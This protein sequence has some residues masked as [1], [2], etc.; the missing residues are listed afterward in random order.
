MKTFGFFA[1]FLLLF[2]LGTTL[3]PANGQNEQVASNRKVMNKVMPVYPRIARSM[4]LTGTVKLEILVAANG[5]PKSIQVKGG[6]P[7]L[8][9]AA[10][11]AI[12]NWRWEK[13]DHETSEMIEFNFRPD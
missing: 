5:Q 11:D 3:R 4:N 12:H 8:V 7:L 9:Q 10:Q 1:F 13:A 2:S 6:S